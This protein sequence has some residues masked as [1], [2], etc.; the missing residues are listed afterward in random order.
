MET[1]L[2][3]HWGP[4]TTTRIPPEAAAPKHQVEQELHQLHQRHDG[5]TEEKTQVPAH[6]TD[7]GVPL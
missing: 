3:Y 4:A 1:V 7:E 6:V 2:T 5:H